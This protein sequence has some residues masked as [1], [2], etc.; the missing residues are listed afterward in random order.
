MYIDDK[1]KINEQINVGIACNLYIKL[2]K[3]KRKFSSSGGGSHLGEV[4]LI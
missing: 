1:Y 3:S 4:I 2:L